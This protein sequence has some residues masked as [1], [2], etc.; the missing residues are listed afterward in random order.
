MD[1]VDI[2]QIQCNPTTKV[3]EYEIMGTEPEVYSHGVTM[4]ANAKNTIGQPT[5]E[6]QITS[7]RCPQTKFHLHI[8][9]FKEEGRVV[10]Y[11]N[12]RGIGKEVVAKNPAQRLLEIMDV[13]D[14]AAK[15]SE[16]REYTRE[17]QQT[18]DEIAARMLGT[19]RSV[20]FSFTQAGMAAYRDEIQRT[21]DPL[22]KLLH[23]EALKYA[24]DW[25]KQR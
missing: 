24:S 3:I 19:P 21:I 11:F 5:V 10:T 4:N 9:G 20:E 6:V 12:F 7:S 22:D 2:R 13:V 23:P 18:L 8:D 1:N 17:G 16:L 25:F 14:K 15:P